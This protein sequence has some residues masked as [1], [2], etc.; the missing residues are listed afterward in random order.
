MSEQNTQQNEAPKPGSDEYNEAMAEKFRNQ[1][2]DG[3]VANQPELAAMAGEQG[4][5]PKPENGH[6]KYY[7]P[8]T[9]E[10]NWEA[11]AREL[12]YNQTRNGSQDERGSETKDRD[13]PDPTN[14]SDEEAAKIVTDAG[15]NVDEVVAHIQDTGN[16]ST[17]HREALKK[18]GLSD[19]LID[20]YLEGQRALAEQVNRQVAEALD[21]AGGEEAWERMNKWAVDNL[22]E[23]QK[24]YVNDLL[25]SGD[26]RMGIDQLREWQ[27]ASSPVARPDM[28][29]EGDVNSRNNVGSYSSRR[30]MVNDIN[31]DKYRNDPSF[32]ELVRRKVLASTWDADNSL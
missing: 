8:Q 16:L 12:E 1:T 10:Y 15:L 31:S 29:V 25:E 28:F 17:E 32:R 24:N 18:A 20:T 21:Y 2:A 26:Y 19:A 11:H 7:N 14:T 3:E 22:N 13:G 27:R 9:G 4:V 6:D 5:R 30:E 23:A